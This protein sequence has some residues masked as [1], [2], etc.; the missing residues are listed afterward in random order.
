MAWLVIM[1][2]ILNHIHNPGKKRTMLT[3]VWNFLFV[4][5]LADSCGKPPELTDNALTLNEHTKS[6][7][8]NASA[9][10]T[11]FKTDNLRNLIQMCQS[12]R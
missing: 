4:Y 12:R 3:F 7:T 11:D 5:F 1:W 8:T 9:R 2:E 6:S 10:N